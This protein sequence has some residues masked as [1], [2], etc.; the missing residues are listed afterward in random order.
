MRI[1]NRRDF[2][3]FDYPIGVKLNRH[4]VNRDYSIGAIMFNRYDVN[5]RD[6]PIGGVFNCQDYSIGVF[7]TKSTITQAA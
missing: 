7:I 6:H 4:D 2:S 5:G 3:W 1:L